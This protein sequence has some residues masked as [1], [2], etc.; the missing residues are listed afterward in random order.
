LPAVH[1]LLDHPEVAGFPRDL[2]KEAARELL[3]DWRSGAAPVPADEADVARRVRDRVAGWLRGRHRPVVNATGV[4]LHTNLGRAP[5][6]EE[7]IQAAIMAAGYGNVEMDLETGRRGGRMA[8][9]SALLRLLTGCEDALVVNN[10]AAALLLVLTTLASGRDVVISRGELVEIGGS[11]RIPEVITAGGARLVEVGTTNRTRA[12]DFARA[13]EAGGPTAVLLRVHRSNFRVVGFVGEPTVAE[14]AEV[15]ASCGASLVV[16]AGSGAL[17]PF[18]DEPVIGTLLREGA[19]VVIFSGDKLLGG[20]Q[21]GLIVGRADLVR[22]AAGH[23]LYRALRVDKVSLAALEATLALHARGGRVPVLDMLA[24]PLEALQ[25]AAEA[26]AAGLRAR[27]WAARVVPGTSV[28]GG[29]SWPGEGLPTALV[30][31]PV[32]DAE[33][34]SRA[35]RLGEPALVARV[36]GGAVLLDPR[37]LSAE[38]RRLLPDWWVRA[39]SSREGNG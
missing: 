31:V 14:L 1:R 15:A 20:P 3:E 9:V 2:V 11:F 28:A 39:L 21:A 7:A 5:W 8:G 10:G 19:D 30:E 18:G 16:D 4:V 36:H 29:G 25:E 17:A 35:L 12:A 22:R 37:T 27:G 24:Q 13:A 38:E 23:P 32:S 33:A 34:A 6:P 26:L